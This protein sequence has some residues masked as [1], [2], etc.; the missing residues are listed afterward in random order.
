MP[1]SLRVASLAL[2]TSAGL[3]LLGACAAPSA[4]DQELAALAAKAEAGD[5]DAAYRHGSRLRRASTLPSDHALG[6]TWLQRAAAQDHRDALIAVGDIAAERGLVKDQVRPDPAAALDHYLRAE[7]LG[8]E[9]AFEAEQPGQE[10]LRAAF[11]CNLW[12]SPSH[13]RSKIHREQD[14]VAG[15]T[16][17]ESFAAMQQRLLVG[18]ATDAESHLRLSWHP[19][20]S[21]EVR[22]AHWQQALAMAH[23]LVVL[24]D[25]WGRAE[26]EFTPEILAA[27][28]RAEHRFAELYGEQAHPLLRLQPKFYERTSRGLAFPEALA[29]LTR[30]WANGTAPGGR[31]R[32]RANWFLAQ[33][34]A[35][36]FHAD[37]AFIDSL[38]TS[39]DIDGSRSAPFAALEAAALYD[40]GRNP[41]LAL[42]LAKRFAAAHEQLPARD[43]NVPYAGR[44]TEELLAIAAAGTDAAIAAEVRTLVAALR[45]TILRKGEEAL[46]DAAAESLFARAKAL[47]ESHRDLYAAPD[48]AA[49]SARIERG[50][51]QA[52]A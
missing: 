21:R 52:Y 8:A 10:T 22:D 14:R 48:R 1:Q 19:E 33:T 7:R 2:L 28:V 25:A 20:G 3:S 6:L 34:I 9:L 41:G 44:R 46:P 49:T 24:H 13:L 32:G 51:Q 50:C 31:Q 29:A 36:G 23:P 27:F 38:V 18:A 43:A 40:A 30:G 35:N 16:A 39:D 15:V 47:T 11:Y 42:Q 17:P 5:A 26:K 37:D 12:G 45:D 4:A